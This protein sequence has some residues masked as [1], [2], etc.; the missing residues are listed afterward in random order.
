MEHP[1]PFGLRFGV[2]RAGTV[3][4]K[5]SCESH[6]ETNPVQVV[7][8]AGVFPSSQHVKVLMEHF[9]MIPNGFIELSILDCLV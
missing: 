5:S 2:F 7:Q 4:W 9:R 3:L 8:V 6:G 1:P